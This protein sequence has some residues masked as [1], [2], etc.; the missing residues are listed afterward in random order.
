MA[1]TKLPPKRRTHSLFGQGC[2]LYDLIPT[3]P[4]MRLLPPI[5]RFAAMLAE[6]PV[7][8]GTFG[9]A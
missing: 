9:T 5:E 8:A 6:L 1:S 4:G 7:I 2:M 3:V